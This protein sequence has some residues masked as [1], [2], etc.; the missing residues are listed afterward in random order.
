MPRWQT[1]KEGAR[2]GPPARG[3][4]GLPREPGLVGVRPRFHDRPGPVP[5][6]I[7]AGGYLEA[8]KRCMSTSMR[9]GCDSMWTAP[10]SCR[11]EARCVSGRLLCW[12]TAARAAGTIRI[13][14]RTSLRLFEAC[15][16]DVRVFCDTVGIA[17]PIVF[18]HSMGV[19]IVLLYGVRHPGHAAGL[20]VQSAFARFD[21]PRLIE[22]FA[23]SLATRWRRSPGAASVDTRCPIRSGIASTSRSGHGCLMKC[24]GP[25]AQES[26][27]QFARDGRRPPNGYRP[28]AWRDHVSDARCGR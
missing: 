20:I 11:M 28:S 22:G 25:A 6:M 26:R 17:R 7:E 2:R 21:I 16:D 19:A 24:K 23:A 4:L 8:A 1:P 5:L 18:G 9:R 15:A 27:A 14:S 3:Q 10:R 12:C 13:S